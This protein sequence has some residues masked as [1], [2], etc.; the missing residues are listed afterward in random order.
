MYLF[1]RNRVDLLFY[2]AM[3]YIPLCIYLNGNDAVNY[4]PAIAI[5]IPL[6]IYLN[7]PQIGQEA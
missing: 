7:C 3:I 4:I 6:C 5:Y 2:L 1:K